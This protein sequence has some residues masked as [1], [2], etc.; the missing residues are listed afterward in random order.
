MACEWRIHVHVPVFLEDLGPFKST[1]FA[2]AEALAFQKKHKLSEQLE[3]E[4][5]TWDVLPD[6]LKT[7]DVV[8]YVCKE[9]EWVKSQLQ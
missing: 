5:Y 2:F 8:D 9:L 1:R 3:I 4:T 7:G 6:H